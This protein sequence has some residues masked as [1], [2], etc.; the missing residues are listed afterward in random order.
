MPDATPDFET[1]RRALEHLLEP[2]DARPASIARGVHHVLGR[3]AAF[4]C[5]VGGGGDGAL[6]LGGAGRRG[7]VR[8]DPEVDHVLD[9]LV[10][11]RL[12]AAH[13]RVLAHAALERHFLV[14]LK[15]IHGCLPRPGGH[16][17]VEVAVR[18]ALTIE[19]GAQQREQ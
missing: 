4:A 17:A 15:A 13:Q 12:R 5:G 8:L 18:R 19:F 14:L 9:R 3:R 2:A 16:R 10:G 11:R 6:G 1:R 7:T